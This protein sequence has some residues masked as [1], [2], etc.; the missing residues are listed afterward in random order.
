MANDNLAHMVIFT[1]LDDTEYDGLN[2]TTTAASLYAMMKARAEG[3]GPVHIVSLIQEV[4][5]I[6][7]SLAEP[8]D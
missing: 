3:K 4:L 2:D 7:C 8:L 1:V 6:Q 5:H